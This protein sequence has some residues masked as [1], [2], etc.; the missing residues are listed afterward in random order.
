MRYNI[1]NSPENRS[2]GCK[3]DDRP[4]LLAS[5]DAVGL[6]N[7]DMVSLVPD[8][9]LGDRR[10]YWRQQLLD[11]DTRN[12]SWLFTV[13]TCFRLGR[14]CLKDTIRMLLIPS[15]PTLI[16]PDHDQWRR[17]VLPNCLFEEKSWSE[18]I[19]KLTTCARESAYIYACMHV[20]CS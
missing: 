20:E 18:E 1:S 19:R 14:H 15:C 7:N 9:N 13:C 8:G 10:R 4:L 5:E 3:D 2:T 17:Y 6:V 16:N 11:R 12:S